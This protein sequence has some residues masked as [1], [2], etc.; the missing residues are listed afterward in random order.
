[1]GGYLLVAAYHQSPM[2][3]GGVISLALEALNELCQQHCASLWEFSAEISVPQTLRKQSERDVCCAGYQIRVENPQSDHRSGV[4][5]RRFQS[6][7][8]WKET[9]LKRSNKELPQ[10]FGEADV[11]MAHEAQT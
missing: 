4:K 10:L 3:W 9:L 8:Q 11:W 1:M 6:Q 5:E 2:G 7:R